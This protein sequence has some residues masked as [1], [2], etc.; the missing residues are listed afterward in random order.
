MK[1][2]WFAIIAFIIMIG[3]CVSE[4]FITDN[5]TNEITQT[6]NFASDLVKEEKYEEAKVYANKAQDLWKKKQ[7]ILFLFT[8]HDRYNM[9]EEYINSLDTWLEVENYEQ[10]LVEATKADLNLNHINQSEDL[11]FANIF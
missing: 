9:F 3:L 4:R 10:F 8:P 1:R 6:I 7:N 11:T 2:I 5:I